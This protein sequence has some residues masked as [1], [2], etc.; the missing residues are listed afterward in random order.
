MIPT[1]PFPISGHSPACPDCAAETQ[2]VQLDGRRVFRCP[3][4]AN[5]RWESGIAA[6]VTVVSC[7]RPLRGPRNPN[8]VDPY[9]V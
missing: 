1:G 7:D 6:G 4:V 8:G 9:V 2:A 5:E 3:W